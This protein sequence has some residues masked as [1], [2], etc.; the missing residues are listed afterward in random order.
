MSE[1]ERR[2][3]VATSFMG[4]S[5]RPHIPMPSNTQSGHCSAIA[6]QI[7]LAISIWSRNKGT[8]PIAL[9]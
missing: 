2:L 7:F 6:K 4:Y 1:R 3:D 9:A 8:F 5:Q